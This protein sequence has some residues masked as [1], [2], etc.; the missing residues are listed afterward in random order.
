LSLV[1]FHQ[2]A[3]KSILIPDWI[4][5]HCPD[6]TLP[7]GKTETG[8]KIWQSNFG[9]WNNRREQKAMEDEALGAPKPLNEFEHGLCSCFGD[10]NVCLLSFFC[11]CLQFGNSWKLMAGP[12]FAN[13]EE[14]V[15]FGACLGFIGIVLINPLFCLVPLPASLWTTRRIFRSRMGYN[16]HDAFDIFASL[17]C[18]PCAIAQNGREAKSF[19]ARKN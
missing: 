7:I 19:A 18:I 5:F 9:R 11:P 13:N 16:T 10:C 14:A 1:N 17:C 4:Y 12:D 2:T 6:A 3:R 8:V 15:Y